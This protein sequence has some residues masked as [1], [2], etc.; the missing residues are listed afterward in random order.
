MASLGTPW[1]IETDGAI[2]MLEDVS[3]QPYRIDRMLQQLRHAGKLE[4]VVGVGVG[5]MVDCEG[6]RYPVPTVHDVVRETFEASGI[7]IVLDLPFGHCDHHLP[8]PVG[9]RAVIDGDRGRVETIES[10][11]A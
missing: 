9:G 3:E 6:T 7:P 5:Q 10:A 1:E 4:A 2:L 11:A 8:W